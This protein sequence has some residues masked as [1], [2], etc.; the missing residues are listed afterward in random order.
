MARTLYRLPFSMA[1]V[2]SR[3]AAKFVMARMAIRAILSP[4]PASESKEQ[5][6][7]DAGEVL[8]TRSIQETLSFDQTTSG[9]VIIWSFGCGLWISCADR[10]LARTC[11]RGTE[12][13]ETTPWTTPFLFFK[14]V[15]TQDDAYN[16]MLDLELVVMRVEDSPCTQDTVRSS[17]RIL[18][19][20]SPP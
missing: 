4:S 14:D 3:A 20:I 9:R 8:P 10:N 5:T 1:P 17:R 2:L 15:R 16:F 6:V 11:C 13:S 19:G 7:S 18:L 12:V